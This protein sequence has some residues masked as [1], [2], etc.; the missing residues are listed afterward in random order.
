MTFHNRGAC[1]SPCTSSQVQLARHSQPNAQSREVAGGAKRRRATGRWSSV[2]CAGAAGRSS[3]GPG[4]TCIFSCI[5]EHNHLGPWRD[6]PEECSSPHNTLSLSQ[7]HHP[8]PPARRLSPIDAS[9][10]FFGWLGI[11]GTCF[12]CPESYLSKFAAILCSFVIVGE[13]F[14]GFSIEF[15]D[16]LSSERMRNVI[17]RRPA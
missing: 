14:L 6:F 4:T 10:S 8:F 1:G 11:C 17:W 7:G 13:C 15:R 3:G 5:G 16:L 2:S 12:K 9:E